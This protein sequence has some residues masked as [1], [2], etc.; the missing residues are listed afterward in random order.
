[1]T[2]PKK[3]TSAECQKFAGTEMNQHSDETLASQIEIPAQKQGSTQNNH[4]RCRRQRAYMQ[5]NTIIG[6]PVSR[7]QSAYMQHNTTVGEPQHNRVGEP[8]YMQQHHHT[9]AGGEVK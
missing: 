8:Q 1:M 2:S 9:R 4:S 3:R 7:R 5:H 6:E